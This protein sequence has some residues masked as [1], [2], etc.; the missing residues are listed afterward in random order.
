MARVARIALDLTLEASKSLKPAIGT[1]WQYAKTE[2]VP[3]MTINFFH[4]PVGKNIED[5]IDKASDSFIAAIQNQ[6]RQIEL[7]EARQ[8]KQREAE[9]KAAEAKIKAEAKRKAEEAK[10]KEEEKLAKEAKARHQAEAEKKAKADQKAAAEAV[11][12]PKTGSTA[13][14]DAPKKK[15]KR[16]K[17]RREKKKGSPPKSNK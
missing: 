3:P 15:A 6:I 11:K 8:I 5:T 14:K 17:N 9:A 7:E 12:A 1:A 16:K 4:G 13:T 10:K 2:I